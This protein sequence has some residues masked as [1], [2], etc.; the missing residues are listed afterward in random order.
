MQRLQALLDTALTETAA[1]WEPVQRAYA[2]VQQAAAILANP[3]HLSAAQVRRRLGG[4]LGAMQ[5]WQNLTGALQVAVTHFHKVTRS[6]WPGLFHCYAVAD[7][8]R[9]NNDLEQL[10]GRFRYLTRRI[11]GRKVLTRSCILRGA[12]RLVAAVSTQ[13]RTFTAQDITPGDPH[14]WRLLRSRLDGRCEQHRRQLRFR[15]NPEAYLAALEEQL[16]KL[17]LPS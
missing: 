4:L 12:V 6:Y 3:K 16:V 11:T 15:K 5:R 1:L 14:A 8:P 7:L 17:V 13:R 2:Y 9:T 10:F